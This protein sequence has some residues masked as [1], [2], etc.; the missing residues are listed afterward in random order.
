[1]AN[2]KEII[3]RR[4]YDAD[5]NPSIEVE[6]CLDN[7]ICALSTAFKSRYDKTEYIKY[8]T[9]NYFGKDVIPHS[10]VPD[11][12]A[13]VYEDGIKDAIDGVNEFIAPAILATNINN[14]EGVD[15]ALATLRKAHR[16]TFNSVANTTL[17]VSCAI[18]AA[19][20]KSNGMLPYRYIRELFSRNKLFELPVP[21]INIFDGGLFTN[22]NLI[23]QSLM[24]AP[25]GAKRF[26]ESLRM[27]AEIFHC[28]KRVLGKKRLGTSVGS[29][30]GYATVFCLGGDTRV[31]NWDTIVTEA[32]ELVILGIT[33][34]GYRPGQDVVLALDV[35]M[36][37]GFYSDKFPYGLTDSNNE[38]VEVRRKEIIHFYKNVVN[39]FPIA[40]IENGFGDDDEI[41]WRELNGA[42]GDKVQMAG[43]DIIFGQDVDKERMATEKVV[44][45]TVCALDRIGTLTEL[46]EKIDFSK[47]Y[48]FTSIICG[49]YGDTED[50]IMADLAVGC[51][52]GF[53]KAGG[54]CRTERV[55]KYNQLLR[56]EGELGKG[57][58]F[59]PPNLGRN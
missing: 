38:Q 17:A 39:A 34:A 19:G 44:N 36:E 31:T 22:N 32:L 48:G 9:P 4:I 53:M 59:Y 43:G 20:A 10:A 50:A 27:G 46:F 12:L 33:E 40:L 3:P 35:D 26:S 52:I 25:V 30:G 18:A 28:V 24:I 37:S 49:G 42:I 8:F 58:S 5:G 54:F 11:S 16:D 6:V 15:S 23:F 21:L 1:M 41:G 45:C 55:A 47:K 14:Q 13:K 51:N 29:Q 57:A 7:G 2:I 56:I